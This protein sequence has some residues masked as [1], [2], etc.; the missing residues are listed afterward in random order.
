M[1]KTDRALIN[2]LLNYAKP[3]IGW[4]V[5]VGV[6]MIVSTIT[7]IS[8]PIVIGRAVDLFTEGY[9]VPLVETSEGKTIVFEGRRLGQLKKGQNVE[10]VS[11]IIH[12]NNVYYWFEHIATEDALELSQLSPNESYHQMHLSEEH[13]EVSLGSN[14]YVGRPL[15][16][17]ELKQ[18][19]SLNYL[20]LAKIGILFLG[21]ILASFVLTYM[22]VIVLQRIGQKIILTIRQEMYEKMLNLPFRFYHE[23]PIGKLVTRVSND[24]E[25]LNQMYTSVLVNLIKH[26]LF[27]VGVTLMMLKTHVQTALC[28]LAML[29]IIIGATAAFKYFSR[30]A[31]NEIRNKLTEMN[32]F[33]SEHLSGM[34]MIQIFRRE[35]AK[36]QEMKKINQK[37]YL[38][39]IKE[40]T[41][42]MIFRPFI[43]FLSYVALAVV[44]YV[45]GRNVLIGSMSIG[46]LVIMI[47]YTKDFFGPIEQLAENY[48]ILQA[49][50]ASSEKIFD[51]LD[52]ENEIT[53]GT[54]TIDSEDFKG[55][56][57]FK[58]VWFAY[59]DE[60]WI[61]KDVSFVI[62]PG[63]KVAFVGATGA[64]KTSI[65]SLI[66]RYYD[67]QKGDILIDGISI[68]NYQIKELRRQIGQVL[69][70]VFMFTGD[71]KTNIR[72]GDRTIDDEQIKRAAQYVN[73][74]EFIMKLPEG[75]NEP[76]IEG[77]ASLSTGQRQLLSFARALAYNPRIFILDE[78]TAHIDTETE[79]LIQDAL[80][81]MMEGRTTLMVA[82]R[83][84][85]IQHADNIIVLHKGR[86][87]ETGK[88]QALLMQK[89]IYY[90]LYELALKGQVTA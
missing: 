12:F 27:V 78:A 21:I 35:E 29:P 59:V 82:H 56:I 13:L 73:A 42:F 75:Y 36:T 31:Y 11:Q 44:L 67:I 89:G 37:L 53:D 19:R 6:C 9:K 10:D 79:G 14:R 49:A 55:R 80:E 45:G 69:Q 85:T 74:H 47:A 24:T 70:D 76:V 66:C 18:L 26:S 41:A 33:L 3:Y 86:I 58:N 39:G 23:N 62:E 2:R 81:K 72:L 1:I 20:P 68:K 28:V 46:A 71:I 48:N 17:D 30:R 88:H 57:E 83:L 34:S 60:D 16:E 50:L 63:Q 54:L 40:L 32:T 4:F 8:K 84:S 43:F 61:L 87:K 22:Q 64:G 90:H 51:I 5:I 52:E 15:K 7:D 38:A 25:N 65:L 77:G